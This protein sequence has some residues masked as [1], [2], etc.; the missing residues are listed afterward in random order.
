MY[1]RYF[2]GG[3]MLSHQQ[4]LTGTINQ[5]KSVLLASLLV[6]VSSSAFAA[7]PDDFPE[8]PALSPSIEHSDIVEHKIKFDDLL[9]KGEELF[10]AKFNTCDGQ[11]RPATTGAGNKRIADQPAFIR[12][13]APESNSCSGCHAQPRDG[14]SG[15][16]VANVFVLAQALDP[17]TVSVSGEFS[18][19]RNTLGMFGAGPIE[20][21]AREMTVDLQSQAAGLT[22]GVHTL[23]SKGV[24][25]DIRVEAGVV[26]ESWGIDTDLVVKPFHQAGVVISLREFTVNAMNHHHGM[27]AEERFDL[28]PA[29]GMDPDF[30][31]D[32]VE[33]ELTV[34][35]I[36]AATLFQAALG[37]PRQVIPKSPEKRLSVKRGSKVFNDIGCASCHV[38]K[39]V[40]NS[41]F[42]EEP[43]PF[44]PPGTFSDTSKTF[45]F[46][47]TR[48]GEFPR[49]KRTGKKGAVVEAYT[50][51][52]RH[53]LCDPVDEPDAI[54]F[55]CNE[56]LDQGRPEQDGR[57]GR[58]FFLTRKL[59][60]VGNS[61]PYGH[62]GDITTLTEAI[63][64][65]GGEARITRDNFDGL[66]KAD[67]V[68]IIDFLQSLQ[69][70]P[71]RK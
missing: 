51:L 24:N 23:S 12:T 60:D 9:K 71:P 64:Y 41:R 21:L 66:E 55:F 26:V 48:S 62:R 3:N 61:A 50:D 68:A 46:D 40:L 42:F 11:G 4:E 29:K 1:L 38:P 14:G 65:H 2:K 52:K 63:L 34:G 69:V 58:E 33:R 25:F 35:D 16:I 36:T 28:N 17:V 37:T 8:A 54:R 13:S 18:N 5:F 30:D 32:G 22:D 10:V 43:N 53:N 27:Q 20:M 15:D 45:K 49:L 70:V 19:S 7:C 6:G 31:E 57:P 56:Q 44:N 67:K 39:M 59:W 47:M